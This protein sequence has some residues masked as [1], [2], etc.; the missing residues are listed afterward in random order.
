MIERTTSVLSSGSRRRP[1]VDENVERLDR[2][3][4]TAPGA[5]LAATALQFI[6]VGVE[7]VL[8]LALL[9]FPVQRI[10][11]DSEINYNEG[12]NAYK[13]ALVARG[14]PLYSA[15]PDLLTG[16]TTYPP[17][18]F[19]LVHL[20]AGRRD[21]VRTG[22]WTSLVS[23]LAAGMFI[24]L[25]VREFGAG[26]MI[27]A[28]SGL[29]W[30]LGIATFLPDRLAMNDPQLLG[31]A[32][33]TAGLYLYIKSRDRASLLCASALA[34]C[35]AGFTKQTLLAF[36]AAVAI[37]LLIHSRRKLAIWLGAMIIFAGLLIALTLA[38]DGRYF[39]SHLLFHRSYS[40][41][42]AFSSITQSYLPAFESVLLVAIVWTL[43]RFRSS[44][45]LAMAFVFANGLAFMLA[46]G[47][48][49]DLNI[50]FNAYAAAVLICGFALS[51]I[52]RG[53]G[54]TAQAARGIRRVSGSAVAAAL[55]AGLFLFMA[56]PFPDQLQDDHAA[57]KLLPAQDAAFRAAVSLLGKTPGPAACENLLLCYRAGKPYAFDAF[58]T[59]DELETQRLGANTLPAMLRRRQ[60]GAVE[61]DTL[62]AEADSS[63]S[64]LVRRRPRFT[65]ESM[66]ALL[67]NYTLT[68]RSPQMLIFVPK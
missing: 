9:W 43:C 11:S 45:L 2:G 18:S 52:E 63:T 4:R 1:V 57:A 27:A 10:N 59:T 62:P 14:V 39:F 42:N 15:P 19:H 60:F 33:T 35:L 65:G 67:D 61:L 38:V 37:H 34:F 26:F 58:V 28:F 41:G 46:G 24:A 54:T 21:L 23:L 17:V 55:M 66:D 68:M 40:P 22:R 32:L 8:V 29:L 48:G 51:E 56:M 31:E 44:P 25:I 50:F 3:D 49:V 6:V 53:L 47:D 12:W 30:I 7:L 36:P 64:P 20:L 16:P 5:P 13:Q